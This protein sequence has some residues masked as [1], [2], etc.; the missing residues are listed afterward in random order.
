MKK[1]K[2]TNEAA[3]GRLGQLKVK[4]KYFLPTYEVHEKKANKS[5]SFCVNNKNESTQ[6]SRRLSD[7]MFLVSA[8][9]EPT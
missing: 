3:V 8:L 7:R 5:T 6:V 2:F 4:N 9:S 1:Q